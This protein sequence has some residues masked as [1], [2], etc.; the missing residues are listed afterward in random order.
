MTTYCQLI[1]RLN[2]VIVSIYYDELLVYFILICHHEIIM[3]QKLS[4]VIN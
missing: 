3:R 1:I 2:H 4:I